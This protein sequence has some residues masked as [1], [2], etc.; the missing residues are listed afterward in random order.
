MTLQWFLAVYSLGSAIVLARLAYL[1]LEKRRAAAAARAATAAARAATAAARAAT[2]AAGETTGNTAGQQQGQQQRRSRRRTRRG[3]WRGRGESSEGGRGLVS[4]SRSSR[5]RSVGGEDGEEDG[6]GGEFDER[7]WESEVRQIY[8][9]H[10]R[11]G[12]AT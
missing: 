8:E 11:I 4:G 1:A 2:A 7:S 12:D 5:S 6:D 3:N 9:A 10:W